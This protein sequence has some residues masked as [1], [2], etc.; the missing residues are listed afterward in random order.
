MAV[1]EVLVQVRVE[2]AVEIL[3]GRKISSVRPHPLRV[4]DDNN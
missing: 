2:V 1:T 4:L 3:M